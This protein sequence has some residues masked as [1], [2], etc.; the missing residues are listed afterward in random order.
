MSS[1]HRARQNYRQWPLQGQPR[2]K[3][4]SELAARASDYNQSLAF[5][6]NRMIPVLFSRAE[7]SGL[8][9][10]AARAHA[11]VLCDGHELRRL[12]EK[13]RSDAGPEGVFESLKFLRDYPS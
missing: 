9:F 2:R 12:H 3:K 7:A 10:Q 5:Y 8:E 4:I 11:V 1:G 6:Q 13:V